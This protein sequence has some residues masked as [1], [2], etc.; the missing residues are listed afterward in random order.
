MRRDAEEAGRLLEL[1]ERQA[2]GLP[3]FTIR[4]QFSRCGQLSNTEPAGTLSATSARV[5]TSVSA[6]SSMPKARAAATTDSPTTQDAA[7][8]HALDEAVLRPEIALQLAVTV[9]MV[10]VEV[11]P[12]HRLGREV[13]QIL[14]LEGADLDDREEGAVGD[15]AMQRRERQADVVR[16]RWR[17]DR[18][19]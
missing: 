13:T 11:R 6:G 2:A 17:R 10:F 16:R 14:R 7:R 3:V 18:R 4:D 1:A 19:A 8:H 9:E 12:Q 15:G 5:A